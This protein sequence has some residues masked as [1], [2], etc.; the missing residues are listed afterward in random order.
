MDLPKRQET[1]ASGCMRRGDSFPVYPQKA[2]HRLNQLQRWVRAAALS[3]DSRDGHETL[4]LLLQPPRILCASTGHYP[5]ALPTPTPP[6]GACEARHCQGSVIQGQLPGRTRCASGCC[7][8]TPAS[9]AAG[10]PHIPI[11]TTIPLPPPG[12]SEPE[13]PNQPLL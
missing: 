11:I 8:V 4:T 3:L 1:I 10:S 13:P 2:E 12:M 5:H 9:A 7:N 6:P